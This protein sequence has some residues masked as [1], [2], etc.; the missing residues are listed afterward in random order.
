[1]KTTKLDE[2][3]FG[4]TRGRIVGLLRGGSGTVNELAEKLELTDN[5]IRAHLLTLERDGLIC[6]SGVQRGS[7]KPHFSYELTPEAEHL[8]PKAYDSLLNQL[9]TTLK[10]RLPP[11]TLEDVLREVGRSLATRHASDHSPTDMESRLQ[12]AVEV[13][14]AIGGSPSIEREDGLI[15]IRSGGCPLSAAVVQHPEVCEVVETLVAQVVGVPVRERCE[16][17]GSPK[18]CFELVNSK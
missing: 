8:F 17:V 10:G 18:C 3:F 12:N 1:M 11:D 2:R 14:R 5:A 13:L 15:F 7:R 4:S 6:Q 9:I 16:R